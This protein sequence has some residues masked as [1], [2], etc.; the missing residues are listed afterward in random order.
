MNT[1]KKKFATAK[2]FKEASDVAKEQ[3]LV[4]AERKDVEDKI[5][6]VHERMEQVRQEHSKL[7][8]DQKRLRDAL[9]AA[10][11]TADEGYLEQL[12]GRRALLMAFLDEA[13]AL[14]E[15]DDDANDANDDEFR[16]TD[17]P[18]HEFSLCMPLVAAELACLDSEESL[19]SLRYPA[20]S[21]EEGEVDEKC[22][23]E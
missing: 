7:I 22:D 4:L 16:P 13:K 1:D 2:K 5:S 19:F 15:G 6:T 10:R 21:S 3:Q 8:G 17:S 14:E 23:V 20:N 9:T 12:K 11:K 18:A